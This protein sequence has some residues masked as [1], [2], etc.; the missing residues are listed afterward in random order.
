VVLALAA[1][2]DRADTSDVSAE[3]YA[4]V[5]LAA[6]V[7][8]RI[9]D[10]EFALAARLPRAIQSKKLLDASS[11]CPHGAIALAYVEW[12]GESEQM[13]EVDWA[14]SRNSEDG[15]PFAAALTARRVLSDAPRAAR[16]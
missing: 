10:S 3:G 1:S 8:R 6:D 13:L 16:R 2:V 9:D 7:S 11:T 14:T 4:P 15:R 5:V 12:F